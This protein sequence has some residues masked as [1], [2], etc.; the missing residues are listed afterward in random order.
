MSNAAHINTPTLSPLKQRFV[1]VYIETGNATKAAKRAGCKCKSDESFRVRGSQLLKELDL[2]IQGLLTA[3]GLNSLKILRT[4]VQGLEAYQV[5]VFVNKD[6]GEITEHRTPDW[7]ARRGFADMAVRLK[8][9]Y[10]KQQM[11][12]QFGMD[13]DKMLVSAEFATASSAG[14]GA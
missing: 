6:T 13:G 12:L 1:D 2:P 10:P 14:D 7:A 4:V 8:G 5:Q 9:G 11:E 3:A